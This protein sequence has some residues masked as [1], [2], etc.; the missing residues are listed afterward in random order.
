[1]KNLTENENKDLFTGAM[2]V[3]MQDLVEYSNHIM[4]KNKGYYFDFDTGFQVINKLMEVS[5]KIKT[6]INKCNIQA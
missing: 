1:M 3:I 5:N 2:Y 4:V 6:Y